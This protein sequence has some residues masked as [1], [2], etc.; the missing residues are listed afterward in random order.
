MIAQIGKQT[1]NL[2]DRKYSENTMRRIL[3]QLV[4]RYKKS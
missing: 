3:D 4:E 2:E 1:Q